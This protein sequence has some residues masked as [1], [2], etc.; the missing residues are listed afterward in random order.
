MPPKGKT[1]GKGGGGKGKGADGD[2]ESSA[3]GKHAKGGAAVK[4]FV[5]H[6]L[7]FR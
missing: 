3:G 4:V 6:E 2:A 1:S 7:I 5:V